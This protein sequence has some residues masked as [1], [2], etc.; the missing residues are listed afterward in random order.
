MNI[1]VEYNYF[2][3]NRNN[4]F[5]KFSNQKIVYIGNDIISIDKSKLIFEQDIFFKIQKDLKD[6]YINFIDSLSEKYNSFDWWISSLHEK[7]IFDDN[8]IFLS[9]CYLKLIL[10]YIK[11]YNNLIFIIKNINLLITIKQ[12]NFKGKYYYNKFYLIKEKFNSFYFYFK[13]R[14]AFLKKRLFEKKTKLNID[15][16]KEY[17]GLISWIDKRNFLSDKSFKENYFAL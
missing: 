8:D 9:L 17:I 6:K 5:N 12:N 16:D 13:N 2:L 11:K 15:I 3:K 1:F 7:N 4:I 10:Y 14:F